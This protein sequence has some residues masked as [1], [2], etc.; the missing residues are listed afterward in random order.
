MWREVDEAE[1]QGKGT[2]KAGAKTQLVITVWVIIVFGLA[3]IVI[4]GEIALPALE[5]IL[6]AIE[7]I[8]MIS[9]IISNCN[10]IINSN[11]NSSKWHYSSLALQ[12]ANAVV[13][14]GKLAQHKLQLFDASMAVAGSYRRSKCVWSFAA[15]LQLF[16]SNLDIIRNWDV[17]DYV[18]F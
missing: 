18:S 7:M 2:D 12:S 6:S 13:E 15:T 3:E 5:A 9:N 1:R 16:Y 4:A 10:I 17:K 14:R 11:S 8:L